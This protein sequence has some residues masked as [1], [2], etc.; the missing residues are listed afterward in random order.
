M[1]R[2]GC[3]LN[4]VIFNIFLDCFCKNDE[5]DLVMKMFYEL[6]LMNCFFDVVIYNVF[7]YGLIK[8]NR[9]KNAFLMFY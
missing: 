6:R 5:V 7:I 2:N 3:Y 8:E 9:V 4:I 1:L